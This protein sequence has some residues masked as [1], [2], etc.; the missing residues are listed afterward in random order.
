MKQV[1]IIGMGALGILYGDLF[2]QTLGKEAVTFLADEK[3]IEKYQRDGVYCNGKKCDFNM[4]S[5]APAADLLIFAV[6]GTGLEQAIEEATKTV[7]E[8]TTIISLLNGISSEEKLI[9]RFGQERVIYCIAQGMDA[10]KL[11][12]RLTYA[13]TGELRIGITGEQQRDAAISARLDALVQFLE[14]AKVP[15]VKEE[16]ILHRLWGKWMLNVG[17]NQVVMVSEGTYATIQKPG[18]EREM[19]LSAMKEVQKLS[20]YEKTGVTAEDIDSYV[21]LVDTLNPDGM[22]SMRQ[23]GL[24]KRYSEVEMFAG[25]VI[26]KAEKYGVSVPTNQ[27]LY[28]RVKEIEA[29]Y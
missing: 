3:R 2:T 26:R 4:T 8:N 17:V 12:N 29:T 14:E 13:H 24:A 21:A 27:E 16:D 18:K 20:E 15:Y 9:E 10:V 25:T 11:E 19:M 23:D 22:P 1:V 5:D 28:K 7:T 6:K